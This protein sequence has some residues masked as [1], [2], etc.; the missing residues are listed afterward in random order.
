MA[1]ADTRHS[2]ESASGTK[3]GPEDPSV[4]RF[5]RHL[6]DER[7]MS[8]ATVRNYG[9]A[10]RCFLDWLGEGGDWRGAEVRQARG[11]AIELQRS[12]SRRT[13]HNRI[14]GIRAFYRYCRETGQVDRNPFASL[15]LPKL[16]K[17]LPKFLTR[18]QMERFLD[19]PSRLLAAATISEAEAWRDRAALELLYGAGLRISEL[20]GADL[21]KFDGSRGLLR[22]LGKGGKE[23]VVPVGKIA[24]FCL[25]QHLHVGGRQGRRDGPL[26]THPSG[27]GVSARWVQVRMKTYLAAADLPRD[28]SPHKLRHSFAT[29]LL[30][31]GADLRSV[32][33]LLGHSSLSTT[34]IYTHTTIG[35]LQEAYRQAHPR[36]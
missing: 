14:A 16:E 19:G 4:E 5:L 24:L 12:L 17:G 27:R 21:A 6:R 28:L 10:I 26:V 25:R 34:Q 33:E 7:R 30:D 35:R 18:E 29:H 13:L 23:R 1:A 2:N 36:A 15:S 9:H 31:E 22:V 32:Q 11:Y 8:P 20:V 3:E